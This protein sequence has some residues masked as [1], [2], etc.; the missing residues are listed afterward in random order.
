MQSLY[1]LGLGYGEKGAKM[2]RQAFLVVIETDHILP[3]SIA[4]N[5][6]CT[7]LKRYA[8]VDKKV[9]YFTNAGQPTFRVRELPLGLQEMTIKEL[10]K[11][12]SEIK[13]MTVELEE[14]VDQTKPGGWD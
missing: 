12:L 3:T 13:K 4:Y 6:L 8:G 1:A 10:F 9:D 14:K 11:E 7:A 5:Y 2:R